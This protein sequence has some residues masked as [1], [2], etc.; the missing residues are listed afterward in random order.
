MKGVPLTPP[1]PL[2]RRTV[3]IGGIRSKTQWF[4]KLLTEIPQCGFCWPNRWHPVVEQGKRDCSISWAPSQGSQNWWQNSCRPSSTPY[5]S[6]SRLTFTNKSKKT[7]FCTP[8]VMQVSVHDVSS[9]TLWK[10]KRDI[11][12]Y[13]HTGDQESAQAETG[14]GKQNGLCAD[15]YVNRSIAR[16]TDL[17]V[18]FLLNIWHLDP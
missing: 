8:T 18:V 11:T 13:F 12:Y 2:P 16:E 15:T 3:R 9:C 10:F 17:L 6:L 5:S 14:W 1:T 4:R 7:N